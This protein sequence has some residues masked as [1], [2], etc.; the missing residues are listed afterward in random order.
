MRHL[1]DS[2]VFIAL[3]VESHPQ[4]EV[5]V[6]WMEGLAEGDELAFCRTTE[7]TF[8][9]LLTVREAMRESVCTNEEAIEK[10]LTLRSD[11]RVVFVDEPNGIGAEFLRFAKHAEPS[12]KRWMDSYLAAF[13]KTTKMK[14]V[15]FDR[16]FAGYKGLDFVLLSTEKE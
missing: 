12:P 3:A 8:L 13:A 11:S 4:H 2:N 1:C 9:R 10:Y 14:F 7:I 16:G 5:A 6:A 15:S